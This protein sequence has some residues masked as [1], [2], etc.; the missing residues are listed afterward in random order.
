MYTFGLLLLLTLATFLVFNLP[1]DTFL[2]KVIILML[3]SA[4]FL[5]VTF[6]FMELKKAHSFWKFSVLTI[7]ILLNFI[8]IIS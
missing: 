5:L 1:L 7:L 4:K 6:Q 2:K 3:F 8:I